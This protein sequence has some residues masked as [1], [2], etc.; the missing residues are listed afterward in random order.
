MGYE[1]QLEGSEG[2]KVMSWKGAELTVARYIGHVAIGTTAD[3]I[4]SSLQEKGVEVMDLIPLPTKHDRFLSFKL[5]IKRSQLSI[6][7]NEQFWPEGVVVGR[8][9][10]AKSPPSD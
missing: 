8:F 2:Y 9:W 4:S 3:A 6:I 10:T 7:E 5:I 1:G